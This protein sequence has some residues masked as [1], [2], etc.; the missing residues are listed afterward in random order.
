VRRIFSGRPDQ[1]ACARDFVR[2]RLGL[3]PVVDEIVLLVSEL[4]TNALLHTASGDGGAFEVTIYLSVGWVRVGVSDNGSS[5]VPL[6]SH[7]EALSEGGRGLALVELIADSWGYDEDHHGR[8]VF[9]D[10]HWTDYA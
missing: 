7:A 8:S 6:L 2:R 9:F 3:V 4:C 1:V 5:Q 10:L